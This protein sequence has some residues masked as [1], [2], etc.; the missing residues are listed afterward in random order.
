MSID[1][2]ECPYQDVCSTIIYWSEERHD[3]ISEVCKTSLYKQCLHYVGSGSCLKA[4]QNREKETKAFC[5]TH[6]YVVFPDTGQRFFVE[7]PE[8]LRVLIIGWAI[9]EWE[10]RCKERGV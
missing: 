8:M 3:F 5:K 6:K 10:R 7:S 9:S 4:A 2:E 1:R